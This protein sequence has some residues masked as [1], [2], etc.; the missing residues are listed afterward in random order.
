MMQIVVLD[1]KL[2][3][4]HVLSERT[5]FRI[6]AL[7]DPSW[8]FQ[9]RTYNRCPMQT[10]DHPPDVRAANYIFMRLVAI[11]HKEFV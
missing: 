4:S 11:A 5:E 8:T 1:G 10:T 3:R 2:I 9:V 6:I 7:F